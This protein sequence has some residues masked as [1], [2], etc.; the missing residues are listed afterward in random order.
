[1]IQT[2]FRQHRGESATKVLL[3]PASGQ[4]IAGFDRSNVFAA[5]LHATLSCIDAVLCLQRLQVCSPSFVRDLTEL[6]AI[7]ILLNPRES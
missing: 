2:R 3:R 7:K 4:Q 5:D 6:E 1:M